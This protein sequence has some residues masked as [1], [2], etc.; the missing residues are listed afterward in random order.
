[1][2]IAIV[3]T[4]TCI[5][6]GFFY[7]LI[8]KC[9]I[10]KQYILV[11]ITNS[12]QM[13]YRKIRGNYVDLRDGSN[14]HMYICKGSDSQWYYTL[15]DEEKKEI[16]CDEPFSFGEYT[17]K[18]IFT[19]KKGGILV[20]LSLFI[21]M[22]TV[23]VFSCQIYFT[24]P[25]GGN[26][27]S[28]VVDINKQSNNKH[29]DNKKAEKKKDRNIHSIVLENESLFSANIS[30]DWNSFKTKARMRRYLENHPS[31]LGISV[32]E[33]NYN[34]NWQEVKKDGIDYALIRL[35]SR[36]YQTG[37]LKEDE[38]FVNNMS[39]AEKNNIKKGVY[40]YS[41]AINKSEMDKEID[42]ILKAIKD[43]SLE[44]P[45]AISLKRY[46]SKM[47][48]RVHS[49]SNEKYIDLI[50]YFCIKIKKKG[51]TPM[52]MGE[53]EWFCQF[54]KDPFNGYLKMVSN[55]NRPPNNINNCIIWEYNESAKGVVKG[56]KTAVELSLSAYN[57]ST[58]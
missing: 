16:Q 42:M 10:N 41:Q 37:K 53:E 44:Y 28:K 11:R 31:E 35:G 40:F 2:L 21:T 51:Y 57:N 34:I 17:F 14:N 9:Y 38:Q 7:L 23:I 20:S 48:T 50:K 6:I 30:I 55:E 12:N 3:L 39:G 46:E 54:K 18:I 22:I 49:L 29:N 25:K 47:E 45:I 32:S 13:Y 8:R 36:G 5:I 27:A 26:N 4:I 58:E 19:E 52:I 56:I 1:M 15:N 33:F 24:I 43:Y